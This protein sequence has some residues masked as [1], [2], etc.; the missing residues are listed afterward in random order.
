MPLPSHYLRNTKGHY[1]EPFAG[2]VHDFSV[3]MR[4]RYD[5]RKVVG[6]YE[7]RPASPRDESLG[8]YMASRHFAMAD[9]GAKID[10][11]IED[12]GATV[13]NRTTAYWADDEGF[14][15]FHPIIARLPHGRGFLA[16]WTMG[17]G[18]CASL[19]RDIIEDEEDARNA[20][21]SIAENAAEAE[22]EFQAEEQ[23]RL[24][25]EEIEAEELEAFGSD[26]VSSLL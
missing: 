17:K 5:S 7:M 6:P 14:T 16:G 1:A 19:D 8:F 15:K 25:A 11:R 22:R 21:H 23:E 3:P 10:L 9:H 18:M 20:A 24:E 13:W 26:I 12:A 4:K 2:K